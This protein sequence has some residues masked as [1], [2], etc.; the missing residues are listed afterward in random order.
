MVATT[1]DIEQRDGAPTRKR[2]VG[3][4]RHGFRPNRRGDRRVPPKPPLHDPQVPGRY[5]VRAELHALRLTAR[6][7]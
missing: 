3:R 4:K 7:A 2:T 1:G 6:P 5:Q